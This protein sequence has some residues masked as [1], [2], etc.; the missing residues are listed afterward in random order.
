MEYIYHCTQ[1]LL[2]PIPAIDLAQQ[3]ELSSKCSH[4]FL[5]WN[6][7]RVYF[8]HF[9]G[10]S[11]LFSI[12]LVLGVIMIAEFVQKV[13]EINFIPAVVFQTQKV[14]LNK[15]FSF[16]TFYSLASGIIIFLVIQ[17]SKNT[18]EPLNFTIGAIWGSFIILNTLGVLAAIKS[19]GTNL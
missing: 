6:L 10:N 13:A 12:F 11:I 14:K 18:P 2:F 16:C 4:D 9:K 7:T 15:R 19:T 5:V 8:C 17:S 3:C 1:E